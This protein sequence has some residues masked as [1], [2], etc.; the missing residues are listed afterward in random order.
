MTDMY[1]HNEL[2]KTDLW[3]HSCKTNFIAIIDFTL[4]GNHQIECP[5][6]GHIHYRK[7]KQGKVTGDRYDSDNHNL[8]TAKVIRDLWKST[9][10]PIQTSTAK[11]F[12]RE[13]WLNRSDSNV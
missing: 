2:T 8:H 7:V 13:K 10:T 4:D 3:C 1:Q 6:C 5:K 12:L 11:H 9:T